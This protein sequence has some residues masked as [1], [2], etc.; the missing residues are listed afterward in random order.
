M[1]SENLYLK[2]G[3]IL[4]SAAYRFQAFDSDCECTGANL[5]FLVR[6]PKSNTLTHFLN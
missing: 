3:A 4:D 1:L 2:L 5:T 6:V